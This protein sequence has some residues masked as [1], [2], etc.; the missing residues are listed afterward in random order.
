MKYQFNST[1][2]VPK[3]IWIFK[4]ETPQTYLQHLN[5]QNIQRYAEQSNF[6]VNFIS[7]DSY[8]EYF[9]NG[10]VEEI[11]KSIEIALKRE[12]IFYFEGE[13]QQYVRQLIAL[14]LL[15]EYG[16]IYIEGSL[17]VT[18]SFDWLR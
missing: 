6:T 7:R 18:E 2:E 11:E 10:F 14:A 3:L 13:N 17:T 15:E 12:A 8:K 5:L 4:D 9:L 16:G 1:F